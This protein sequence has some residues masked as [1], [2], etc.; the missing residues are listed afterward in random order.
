MANDVTAAGALPPAAE[1]PPEPAVLFYILSFL[2][3]L[4]GLIVGA[5]YLSKSIPAQKEFGKLCLILALARMGIAFI[6]AVVVVI[7]AVVI[8][9]AVFIAL[10]AGGAGGM[11]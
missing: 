7:V 3:P 11:H 2:I 1:R 6:V 10:I 9:A 4:V 8:Y 5:I